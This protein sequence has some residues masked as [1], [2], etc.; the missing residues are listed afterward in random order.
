MKVQDLLIRGD[1]EHAIEE[2]ILI[3]D[4]ATALLV[5]SMCDPDTYKRVARKYAES[6]FRSDSP[7]YTTTM[8]F[9]GKIEA[10]SSR[11]SGNWG[12]K[13]DDLKENWK[14]HL[15]SIINNRTFGWDKIVL[16][17]GDRL[18]EIGF[19]K[20]AHFCYMVCGYPITSPTDE[21]TRAALLGCDHSEY[22]NRT[23][24]TGESIVAYERTEAYEWA[25]RLGNQHAYFATFQPF[26]LIY[27]MLLA[28]KGDLTQAQK[29]MRSIQIST[30]ESRRASSEIKRV[31][32]DQMFGDDV[33]FELAYSEVEEQ[34][35]KGGAELKYSAVLNG[36]ALEITTP[37][38]LRVNTNAEPSQKFDSSSL[39]KRNDE[40]WSDFSKTS[41]NDP[42]ATFMTA[43]SNLMDVSGFALTPTAEGPAV[44][45]ETSGKNDFK[46][47]TQPAK[48][49]PVSSV[50]AR[51]M[52]TSPQPQYAKKPA[53]SNER[54]ASWQ[55]KEPKQQERPKAAPATAPAVMT[56]KKNEKAKST[57]P[58]P[59]SSGKPKK[60]PASG[61]FGG[62][63]SWLIKKLNPDSTECYLPESEEQPYYDKELKRKSLAFCNHRLWNKQNFY[64]SCSAFS[65][66]IMIKWR[67]TQ[68]RTSSL[69]C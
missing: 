48:S 21:E 3:G 27:S 39:Q 54:I 19:F 55:Q 43:K 35:V 12:V 53:T 60:A 67:L 30:D 63:K 44:S 37:K 52:K 65:R 66:L 24:L 49:N 17:L 42:D 59:A 22:Q 8:L 50:A 41:N 47:G 9:S 6:K 56:G 18:N 64:V 2:A 33:A 57:T 62:M 4:F 31:S 20:E 11:K 40:P 1:R 46:A 28:D 36:G 13:P 25:K 34:L 32:V 5:A 29:F 15:A 45:V 26:K 23:L 69:L 10:P 7:M 16:S 61:A 58:A 14:S 38:A 51:E 68:S